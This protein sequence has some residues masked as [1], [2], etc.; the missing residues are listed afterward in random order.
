MSWF[1]RKEN[2]CSPLL[3]GTDVQHLSFRFAS[4]APAHPG[5]T[6]T[7]HLRMR[8]FLNGNKFGLGQL[9]RH[10][11]KGNRHPRPIKVGDTP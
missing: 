5:K 4:R 7:T 1:L 9:M 3:D 10:R 11:E 6:G 8:V 2:E